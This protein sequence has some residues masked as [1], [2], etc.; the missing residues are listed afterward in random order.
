MKA[1]SFQELRNLPKPL[2]LLYQLGF[3][4]AE[5]FL[6]LN[7]ASNIANRPVH[8]NKI[9]SRHKKGLVSIHWS[10]FDDRGKT[11]FFVLYFLRWFGRVYFSW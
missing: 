11:H 7:R 6:S 9:S 3:N 8:P 4:L 5:E 2:R 10:I 1:S